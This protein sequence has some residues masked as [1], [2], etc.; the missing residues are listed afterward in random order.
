MKQKKIVIG[1]RYGHLK[2]IKKTDLNDHGYCIYECLCDCGRMINVDS[3]RL[4]RGTVQDCGCH[5]TKKINKGNISDD[6]TGMVF[7]N[8]T[9]LQ[10]EKSQ[11]GRVRWLCRCS[12]GQQKIVTAHELKLGKTKSCGCQHYVR[13]RYYKD[14]S[15]QRFDRLVALYP[16]LKRNSQGSIYWHCLCDCGQEIDVS[17]DALIQNKCHSCGCLQK[18]MKKKVHNQLHMID[19]T[20]IEF[21]E[22]RKERKDNRSGFRGVYLKKNGCY[23]VTIGFKGKR[24]YIGSYHS[25]EEAVMKRIE[26]EEDIFGGFLNAYYK[27]QEKA[28][29]NEDWAKKNPLIYEVEKKDGK[30]KTYTNMY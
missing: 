14:I 23:Q 12:C 2:I 27:W 9:V 10:K 3:R 6:L 15:G 7:G 1:E 19:H 24:Y 25:Y 17:E 29:L 30:I 13:G 16:T 8:L 26:A 20:C 18:E 22:K 5:L 11:K 21:L 4:K 28:Q